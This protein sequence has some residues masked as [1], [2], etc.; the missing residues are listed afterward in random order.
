MLIEDMS[1]Q[2]FF[3]KY[4]DVLEELNQLKAD[5][6]ALIDYRFNDKRTTTGNC[7][8]LSSSKMVIHS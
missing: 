4:Q 5:H 8:I 6:E 1:N 7:L 2:A 3:N